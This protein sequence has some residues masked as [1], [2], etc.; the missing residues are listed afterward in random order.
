MIAKVSTVEVRRRVGDLVDRG[1]QRHH[2]FIP[3]PPGPGVRSSRGAMSPDPLGGFAAE[4]SA[5]ELEVV[6]RLQVQPELRAVA[7]VEAEA[8]RGVGADPAPAVDDLG[9]AVRRDTDRPGELVLRQA[10]FL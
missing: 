5:G 2:E 7:E 8:E 9:D 10:V 6:V 3:M 4:L 1:A